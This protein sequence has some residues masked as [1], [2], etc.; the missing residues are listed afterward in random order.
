MINYERIKA[1][2]IEEMSEFLCDH[3]DCYFICPA[4]DRDYCSSDKLKVCSIAMKKY[5]ESEDL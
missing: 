5:L 1:M 3:F 2:S 4:K